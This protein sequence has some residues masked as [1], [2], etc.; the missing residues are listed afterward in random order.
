MS[1]YIIYHP[2]SGRMHTGNTLADLAISTGSIRF[3]IEQSRIYVD[4][5]PD[6]VSWPEEF[7]G[8]ELWREVGK[9]A[10]E[11]L[12]RRGWALYERSES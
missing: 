5:Q 3:S 1:R 11:L 7:S 10:L 2:L 4:G 12:R 6:S 9:R 8:V